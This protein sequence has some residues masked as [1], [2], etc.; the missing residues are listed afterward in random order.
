MVQGE[1]CC[2]E[3]KQLI[4]NLPSNPPL[5]PPP[6]QGIQHQAWGGS[7]ARFLL[8]VL[9]QLDMTVLHQSFKT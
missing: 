7:F 8:Q 1:G 3:A 2:Q 9:T 5:A 4:P 6:A